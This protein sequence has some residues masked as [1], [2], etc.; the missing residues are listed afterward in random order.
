MFESQGGLG[1]KQISASLMLLG[2]DCLTLRCGSQG[3]IGIILLPIGSFVKG[4]LDV[5]HE[6]QHCEPGFSGCFMRDYRG[7]TTF[8]QSVFEIHASRPVGW[9]SR[10][11]DRIKLQV[12]TV[13][14]VYMFGNFA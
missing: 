2:R 11:P 12:M 5:V 13:L 6:V 3:T 7:V 4:I 14:Y 8:A 10:R 9:L 1:E